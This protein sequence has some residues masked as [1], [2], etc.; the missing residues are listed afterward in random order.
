MLWIS[1]GSRVR[2]VA[3]SC[4]CHTRSFHAS[5][6]RSEAGCCSPAAGMSVFWARCDLPVARKRQH[7]TSYSLSIPRAIRVR[8][9]S[10]RWQGLFKLILPTYT[11]LAFD[12]FFRTSIF[13]GSR[14]TS[15]TPDVVVIFLTYSAGPPCKP[16]S[17]EAVICPTN[18]NYPAQIRTLLS[19]TLSAFDSKH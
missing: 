4:A 12:T 16:L 11:Y 9:Q 18:I 6:H 19:Y 15:G 2:P 13:N 1:T 8:L 3:C 14:C 10:C 7:H 17:H 5:T